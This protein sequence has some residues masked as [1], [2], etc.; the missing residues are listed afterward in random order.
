MGM[1]FVLKIIEEHVFFIIC[2]TA[3]YAS[4]CTFYD[5][6]DYVLNFIKVNQCVQNPLEK[7]SRTCI[8][9]ASR[10]RCLKIFKVNNTSLRDCLVKLYYFDAI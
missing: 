8:R 4:N 5:D 7:C 6:I 9:R 1:G 2:V 3:K 10:L